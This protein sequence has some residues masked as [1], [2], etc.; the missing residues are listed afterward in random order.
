MNRIIFDFGA[1]QGQNINYFLERADYLICVEA[2]NQLCEKMREKYK[3]NIDSGSLFVENYAV[4]NQEFEKKVF[5][6]YKNKSN[7]RRRN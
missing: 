2:N 5:Y 1:N 7:S 6:I 3:T 4:S